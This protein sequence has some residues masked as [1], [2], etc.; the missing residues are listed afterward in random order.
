MR[1]IG[2][3]VLGLAALLGVAWIYRAEIV[4][5]GI[6]HL[7]A[8]RAEI[9]PPREIVWATG[10]DPEG[11]AP[12]ER[13][14]NIALILAD[15]LGW[16]DV[17]M[18]GPAATART[19]NID[20][21]AA[22]GVRFSQGYAANAT[23]AP[24]RAA[25]LS[26][27]YGTRFGFEFTP[28]P[29][30]FLPLVRF[31]SG[32]IDR[33][34]QPAGLVNPEPPGLGYE[35]M[36]MPASEITLAERLA[37]RGY[38][39]VHIGK[40]HLGT[41]N[42]MA[43]HEQGFAESL[44][45]T[46]AGYGRRDDEDVIEAVQDFDPI[47]RLV[48]AAGQSAVRFNGGPAFEPPRYLTDYFTDEAVRVLEANRD[49]P[50]FLYLAHY[51]P[52]TPLQASRERYEATAESDPHRKRVYAAMI[53]SLDRGV[54]RLM[55]ALENKGL[56]ENTLVIFTSDNG[57]AGYIGLPDVNA[58]YRGWKST[59]FEG[60]LRVPFLVRWPASFPA[61]AVFEAPVH[62]FDLHETVAAAAGAERPT[63]RVMDGV[64]LAPFV[65]S[66]GRAARPHD[67]LFF[68]SGAASAVRDDRWKLVVSAPPGMPRR[69]WLF[70]LDADGEGTDLLA[71]HPEV[72]ERLRK[73]LA[74]HEREQVEPLWPW[75]V[76]TAI[77]VDRDQS[78]PDRPDDD[79][80]FWSN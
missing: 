44:L 72:A 40:W 42:G 22:E 76:T 9:E 23:C 78:Q 41:A 56:D 73:V 27:R 39:T 77:N 65:T 24:S 66:G 6:E 18:N 55:A 12:V 20:A 57:A 32:T 69:E 4:L 10:A 51:A 37:G 47:T 58:P 15:D 28:M 74:A 71:E 63:D 13:P 64:D 16:S 3:I 59:M 14:P 79:F 35:E 11:R 54:G 31:L 60:G 50:F 46:G 80:A 48:S 52:H 5:F 21:L 67:H 17:S 43:P 26:G 70:D 49:R 7:A 75:T 30:G 45:M 33:P 29:T 36:G 19:P 61:G 68:R 62:H 2:G 25:L 1:R 38:H 53:E 34:L 8:A